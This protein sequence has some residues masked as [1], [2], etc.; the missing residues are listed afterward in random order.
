MKKTYLKPHSKVLDF[1]TS[2]DTMQNPPKDPYGSYIVNELEPDDPIVIG[3]DD[4][5]NA[6]PSPWRNSLWD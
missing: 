2:R 6:K 1:S 3:G 4:G 5:D